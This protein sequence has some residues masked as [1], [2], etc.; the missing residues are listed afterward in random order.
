MSNGTVTIDARYKNDQSQVMSIGRIKVGNN[1]I[2]RP[3]D[4]GLRTVKSIHF[5]PWTQS[6]N[7]I[8]PGTIGGSMAAKNYLRTLNRKTAIV[9]GSIG[10]LGVLDTSTTGATPIGNY[11]RVRAYTLA[12]FGTW[13]GNYTLILG[14][15]AGSIRASFLAVGR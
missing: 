6:P 7:P 15:Q 4:L 10:S 3:Q 12:P 2:I 8:V 13:V 11:V 9:T 14:T 1:D 5:T